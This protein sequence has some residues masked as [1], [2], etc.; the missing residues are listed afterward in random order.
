MARTTL[1]R[2]ILTGAVAVLAT[3]G[4]AAGPAAGAAQAQPALPDV[5]GSS[6]PE[7]SLPSTQFAGKWVDLDPSGG[8]ELT[9]HNGRLSGTDGCNGIGTTYTTAGNVAFVEPFMSTM[10][11][12]TG[13]WSQWLTQVKTIHHYGVAMTV[14]GADGQL[15]GVLRP[16]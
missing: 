11:A 15:L 12:C 10:M 2:R 6:L 4:L 7:S 14:H 9:F 1:K 13:P 8:G 3:A 16:A 5:S